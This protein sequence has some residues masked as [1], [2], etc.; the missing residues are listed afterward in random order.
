MPAVSPVFDF[1]YDRVMRSVVE[2]L[3]CLSLDRIDI[4]HIQDP[5]DHYP[6]A[7]EGAYREGLLDEELPTP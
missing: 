5:D 7:L 6:A 3:E 1:S 2:S 4:L